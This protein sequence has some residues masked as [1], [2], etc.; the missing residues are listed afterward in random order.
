MGVVAASAVTA[1]VVVV[2]VVV[3]IAGV[4]FSLSLSVDVPVSKNIISIPNH[5]IIIN[6]AV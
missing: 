3:G 2:V 6:T 4:V 1:V 5:H